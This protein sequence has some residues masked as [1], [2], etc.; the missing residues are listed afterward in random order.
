MCLVALS[1]LHPQ[2]DITCYKLVYLYEDEDGHRFF[3]SPYYTIDTWELGKTKR[4]WQPEPKDIRWFVET[5]DGFP[6]CWPSY[7][8]GPVITEYAF[9]SFKTVDGAVELKEILDTVSWDHIHSRAKGQ[10]IVECKIPKDSQY[11]WK[12]RDDGTQAEAYASESLQFV[13]II[14]YYY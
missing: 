13:K 11:V 3:R 8:V 12:G 1:K 4:V 5:G 7:A 2:E 6:R 10:A 14:K 9:H